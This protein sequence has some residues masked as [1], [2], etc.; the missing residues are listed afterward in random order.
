MKEPK[1]E[2]ILDYKKGSPERT[3]LEEA[4]KKYQATVTDIPIIIGSE[5]HKTKDVQQ[6]VMVCEFNKIFKTYNT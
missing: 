5:E 2:P 4:L 3:A 1:N 6:Q